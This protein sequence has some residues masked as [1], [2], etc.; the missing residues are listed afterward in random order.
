MVTYL[1]AV[2][3]DI[4]LAIRLLTTT[5]PNEAPDLGAWAREAHNLL[6]TINNLPAIHNSTPDLVATEEQLAATRAT[7][8]RLTIRLLDAP[9]R[10]APELA[11][12]RPATVPLPDSFEGDP[13]EYLDIKTKLN[14]KFRADTPTF[15]DDQH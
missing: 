1:T 4:L 3:D 6:T 13:K 14:N 10:P 15:R 9:E 12:A 2:P 11:R 8:E 5:A 7:I